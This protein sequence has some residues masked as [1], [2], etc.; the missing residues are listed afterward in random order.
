LLRDQALSAP[1][2]FFAPAKELSNRHSLSISEFRVALQPLLEVLFRTEEIIDASA[3]SAEDER[4]DGSYLRDAASHNHHRDGLQAVRA[5]VFYL[6]CIVRVGAVDQQQE[7]HRSRHFELVAPV[8]FNLMRLKIDTIRGT[9]WK[10]VGEVVA[11]VFAF[12]F[13]QHNAQLTHELETRLQ[14]PRW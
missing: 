11:E 3:T 8:D 4:S 2:S 6:E 12:L 14:W 9:T 10:A 1:D 5:R 13:R 7:V